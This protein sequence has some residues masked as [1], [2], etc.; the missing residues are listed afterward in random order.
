MTGH[1]AKRIVIFGATGTVGAGAL[2]ECLDHPG[3]GEVVCVVRRPTGRSHAKLR[4]LLHQD[5]SDFSPLASELRGV[6][7]CLW[8][9]GVPQLGRTEEEYK[10]VTHD[11]AVAAARV[12]HEQSPECCFV[13]VSGAGADETGTSSLMWARVKGMTES[14]ILD[15]GFGRTLI[16][17]PGAIVAKRGI[18]H[19]ERVYALAALLGP[20]MRPFGL[21]TS[22]VD[23]GRAL[24]A[25]VLGKSVDP[26]EKV[27]LDSVGINELAKLAAKQVETGGTRAARQN[28]KT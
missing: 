21:A 15:M 8:A 13:F 6:D 23:I 14:A 16:F 2:L 17:R 25:A 4:E 1:R 3:V 20:L 7:G 10:E 27:R 26:P 9:V 22:T 24:I 12:L 18:R 19:S 5:F 11:Y 28:R